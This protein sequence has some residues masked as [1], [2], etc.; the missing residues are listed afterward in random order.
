MFV[1]RPV[2]SDPPLCTLR[3]LETFYSIDRLAD[4]HEVL[5]LK[6]AMQDRARQEAE[7]KRR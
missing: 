7:R 4:F 5:N 1:W 6:E 2:I 3:D